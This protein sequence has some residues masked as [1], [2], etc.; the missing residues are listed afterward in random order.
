MAATSAETDMSRMTLAQARQ[1]IERC[2]SLLRLLLSLERPG[3]HRLRTRQ[4]QGPKAK[5]SSKER[6]LDHTCCATTLGWGL[7]RGSWR[8][9]RHVTH[10]PERARRAQVHLETVGRDWVT[11]A[12]PIA[13]T[14]LGL[15]NFTVVNL[16]GK[17]ILDSGHDVHRWCG[18]SSKDSRALPG[19]GLTLTYRV[20]SRLRFYCVLPVT[21]QPWRVVF[22]IHCLLPSFRQPGRG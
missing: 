22:H 8:G 12:G 18:L 3:Q 5:G 14:V 4:R 1:L 20:V 10:L 13:I 2:V 17:L 16:D 7:S 21:S 6:D 11:V 15:H 19:H 9:R